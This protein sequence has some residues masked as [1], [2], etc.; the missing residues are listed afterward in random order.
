LNN[1]LKTQEANKCK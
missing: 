1:N